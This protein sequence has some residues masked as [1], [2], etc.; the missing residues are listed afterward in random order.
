MDDLVDTVD[1]PEQILEHR[2]LADRVELLVPCMAG[3]SKHKY[4]QDDTTAN[5]LHY[6]LVHLMYP[7]QLLQEQS[8]N[9]YM[10]THH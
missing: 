8:I 6:N 5:M 3:L 2:Y 9:I 1:M 7:A 10:T 4:C